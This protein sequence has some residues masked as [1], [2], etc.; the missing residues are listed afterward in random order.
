MGLHDGPADRQAHAE[1]PRPGAGEPLDSDIGEAHRHSRKQLGAVAQG[2]AQRRAVRGEHEV[3]RGPA[4]TAGAAV[5]R[6]ATSPQL[7]TIRR[8]TTPRRP[9]VTAWSRP[10][11]LVNRSGP[12]RTT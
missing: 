10:G 12:T 9:L 8:P 2:K 5:T 3:E 11:P 1:S 6:S 4:V 7:L